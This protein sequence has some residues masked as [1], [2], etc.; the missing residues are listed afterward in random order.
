[1]TRINQTTSVLFISLAICSSTGLEAQQR[2]NRR[3]LG[4]P[5]LGIEKGTTEFKTPLFQLG[6]L[7]STQT[8]ASL[9][10][11]DASPFDF[12][13]GDRL[14]E[15]DKNGFYHLG[16]IT[17]GLRSVND[18]GWTY[19]SS[20]KVRVDIDPVKSD[21]PDVL[22]AADLAKTL[23]A[24][25]PVG[26]IRYWEKDGDNLVMRFEVSNIS[27]K[28]V[29]IGALGIPMVFNNNF[30]GKSL[31]R[32]HA[33]NVFFDPY[34]GSD[35]GYLQVI[36]LDGK[37]KVLVVVP[38]GNT[39]FEAYR[40]LLDDPLPSG[41]TF[42]GLHEWMVHSKS[43]AE[44]A[45]KGVE[46]WNVPTSEIIKPGESRNYGVKFLIA[47]S[48]REIEDALEQAD[49]PVAVGIPRLRGSHG[50]QCKAL[51]EI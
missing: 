24:G 22:S 28:P 17:M 4:A 32:A 27:D 33:E 38:Y 40:P 30:N 25:I 11:N 10:T 19:Y 42:E 15:R 41:Y 49:R 5:T 8:V 6:L 45:W 34:I 20:A 43:Y 16:D 14:K 21:D 46:Q 31:E 2:G 26:I 44:T 50:C 47:G 35:A 23:P 48:V 37:G 3:D 18:T 29:E 36:R 1:M 51:P 7:S 9:K 13:P 39:S 12:T